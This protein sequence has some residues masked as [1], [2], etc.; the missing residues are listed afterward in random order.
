MCPWW[1]KGGDLDVYKWSLWGRRNPGFQDVAISNCIVVSTISRKN[2]HTR[3][4]IFV[5]L[6]RSLVPVCILRESLG[7]KMQTGSRALAAERNEVKNSDWSWWEPESHVVNQSPGSLPPDCHLAKERVFS[8]IS[9]SPRKPHYAKYKSQKAEEFFYSGN[10]RRLISHRVFSLKAQ[11]GRD[12]I[13]SSVFQRW[14]IKNSLFLTKGTNN[15]IVLLAE[16]KVLIWNSWQN[17]N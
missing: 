10:N 12:T 3:G 9:P 1:H 2:N 13:W 4:C 8:P 14:E 7:I 16:Q 11:G 17:S 6:T 5:W 15:P